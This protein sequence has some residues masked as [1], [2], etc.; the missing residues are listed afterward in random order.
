MKLSRDEKALFDAVQKGDARRVKSLLKKGVDPEITDQYFDTPL[1]MAIRRGHLPVVKAL[2]EAGADVNRPSDDGDNP[3]DLAQFF[4]EKEIAKFLKKNGAVKKPPEDDDDGYS[5]YGGSRRTAARRGSD[6]YFDDDYYYL[7]SAERARRDKSAAPVRGSRSAAPQPADPAPAEEPKFREETLKDVF[8]A[9]NWVGKT[10]EMKQ[11][12]TEV[13]KKLQ[14][15][16]DFAAALSEARHETLRVNA[17]KAPRL[18][19]RR[20]GQDAAPPQEPKP[21]APTP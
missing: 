3:L 8:N 21:P 5:A 2:V 7:D 10:E 11:L 18:A 20:E 15:T 17:P 14:K 4:G 12:W 19:P 16:F 13:P 9:R 1:E 6:D